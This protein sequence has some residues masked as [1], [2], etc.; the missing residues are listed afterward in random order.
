MSCELLLPRYVLR[1]DSSQDIVSTLS[2]TIFGITNLR[3]W[4]LGIFWINLPII[5]AGIIAIFFFLKLAQTPGKVLEKIQR[6]DWIG[7]VFFIASAV[8]FLIPLTWGE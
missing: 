6:F 2:S 1:V 5:G 8:S 3:F 4:G 7:S